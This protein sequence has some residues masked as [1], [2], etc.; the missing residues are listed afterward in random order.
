MT[1]AIPTFML[2]GDPPGEAEPAFVHVE[3]IPTRGRLVDWTIRPHRHT[4]LRHAL[5]VSG[6]GGLF[7]ADE[8]VRPFRAP[9]FLA[10]PVGVVHGF[11]FEPETQGQVLTM[12]DGFV[13][14]ALAGVR[15]PALRAALEVPLMLDLDAGDPALPDLAH[16]FAAVEREFLW[17]GVGRATAIAAHIALILVTVARLGLDGSAAADMAGPDLR[18]VGRLRQL[19]EQRFREHWAVEAYADALG[20]TAGRLNT[21]C[22]RVAGCSTLRLVHNRLLLEA[23]RNLIYTAMT[24]SEVGYHLGFDDPAYFSRFFTK[25]EGMTPQAYRQHHIRGPAD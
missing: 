25:R 13:S 7:R 24:M 6:G 21:A 17:S 4:G 2:Y 10:V 19:V 12:S 5:L 22:R 8:A 1:N 23:K 20:V 3:S 14:D 11:D 18:L 9:A 15:E 16:A